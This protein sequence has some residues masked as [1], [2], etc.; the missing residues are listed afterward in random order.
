MSSVTF[1]TTPLN[2]NWHRWSFPRESPRLSV[3]L[4]PYSLFCVHGP[5]KSSAL[6]GELGA[7]SDTHRAYR[8]ASQQHSPA[9][10]STKSKMPLYNILT[11]GSIV[12]GSFPEP[13]EKASADLTVQC[14]GYFLFSSLCFFF[15]QL[16]VRQH[17]VGT[18]AVPPFFLHLIKQGF[19]ASFSSRLSVCG[20]H[21]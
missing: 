3:M 18:G 20:D 10:V 9:S 11:R 16:S 1:V 2:F 19:S 6:Y 4:A 17:S 5:V 21:S 15:L 13:M 7:I 14:W 12:I 8:L